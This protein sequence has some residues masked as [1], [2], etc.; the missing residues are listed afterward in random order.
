MMKLRSH[1]CFVLLFLLLLSGCGSTPDT[2][3]FTASGYLADRGAVRIWRKNSGHITVHLRML[4][5]PFNGDAAETT[6]YVWQE[7]KLVSVASYVSGKQPAAFRLGRQTE[8]Y[9]AAASRPPT[10]SGRYGYG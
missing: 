1:S 4:Y 3:P 2:S 6:D 10:R 8:F 9:A 5:T 7:E